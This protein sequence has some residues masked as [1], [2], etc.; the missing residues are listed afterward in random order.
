M[1][2]PH[3]PR[4]SA[5]LYPSSL[6]H[7]SMYDPAVPV[8]SYWEETA[9]EDETGAPFEGTQ[10]CDVAIIG[11]GYTGLSAAYHLA[12]DHD[13]DVCLL[14][15]GPLGWGASGRNGGFCAPYPSSLSLEEMVRRF[16]ADEA[17]RFLQTQEE[18]VELVRHLA[19]SENMDIAP[20]GNG[21]WY[22]AHDERRFAHL[23]EMAETL[24]S[25]FRQEVRLAP[26]EEVAA[27]VYDSEEQ[28]GGMWWKLGF[29]L[30]PLRF[31]RGLARAARRAGAQLYGNSPVTEWRKKEGVH[32][33]ITPRGRLLARRVIL[34]TNGFTPEKLHPSFDGGTLP[35]MSNIIVTRPLTAEELAAQNWRTDCPC[36]NTRN[37]LFYYR[38]LPDGRF[39]FGGRGDT[40]GTPQ[41][42][43]HMKAHLTRRM[44]EVFPAWGGVP[45]THYWRGFVCMTRNLRPAIGALPEDRSVYYGLGYHGDGVASAPWTGRLLAR[46]IAGEAE[47]KDIPLMMRGPL[48]TFAFPSLRRWYLRGALVYY[49]M[50]DL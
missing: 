15:A 35:V 8:G 25:V 38:V 9:G 43:A 7:S 2:V 24:R 26:R 5:A 6:Y 46:L 19:E 4:S 14:E 47:T 50:T 1:S 36:T 13:I 17:R 34:A 16:G 18:A 33:L 29:G 44:G 49:F 39:M 11:G 10:A 30:H 41:G 12:R 20:Q 45:V 22:I 23:E 42:A 48:K 21:F 37:L 27:R 40:A 3:R 32:E 28:F 31:A